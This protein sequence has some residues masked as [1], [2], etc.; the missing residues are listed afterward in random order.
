MRPNDCLNMIDDE[1]PLDIR[2]PET[3]SEAGEWLATGPGVIGLVILGVTLLVDAV[4]F[5]VC[6]F[7]AVTIFLIFVSVILLYVIG[8][9]T[10]LL[11]GIGAVI[12]LIGAICTIRRPAALTVNLIGFFANAGAVGLASWLMSLL[13]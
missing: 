12:C 9:L 5:L 3:A 4:L 7:F 11:C 10:I 2:Q 13:P 6:M 8:G 1:A